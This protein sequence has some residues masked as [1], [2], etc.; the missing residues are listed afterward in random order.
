[1]RA[2]RAEAQHIANKERREEVLKQLDQVEELIPQQLLLAEQ[3]AESPSDVSLQ[4]KLEEISDSITE[5]LEDA[6]A[7][8]PQY[9]T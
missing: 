8:S 6:L 9:E 1:M 7:A 2:A 5:V 3:L 4:E